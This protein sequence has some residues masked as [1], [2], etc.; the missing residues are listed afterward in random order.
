MKSATNVIKFLNQQLT[1]HLTSINMYF[2]HARMLKNWGLEELNDHAY[3]FSIH[4]MKVADK[5]IQRIFML[6]GLPNLQDIKKLKIGEN[7]KEILECMH[8]HE[9]A[10]HEAAVEAIH[11][12]ESVKDFVSRDLLED[13]LEASDDRVDWIETELELIEKMGLENYIQSQVEED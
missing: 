9:K 13:I 11:H 6:E 2:L 8:S 5:L 12:C 1:H 3:K 10:T 4:E 7:V